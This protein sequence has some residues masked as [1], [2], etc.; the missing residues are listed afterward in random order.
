MKKKGL[1]ISTVVMVVVLIASLTTATYAWFTASNKTE[2]KGF[3]VS[4][5]SGNAVNIGMKKTYGFA[6]SATPDLFATGDV[7]FTVPTGGSTGAGNVNNPGEWGGTSDGFSATLNHNINWG[8]QKQAVGVTAEAD[9]TAD[10]VQTKT[11]ITN[12]TYWVNHNTDK[13]VVTYLNNNANKRT[14]VAANKAQGED[15]LVEQKLARANIGENDGDAG[16]YAHFILG[17]QPTKALSRNNFVI[18]VSPST[19]TS[20]LGVLASIHV[21]YRTKLDGQTASDWT[22]VDLYQNNH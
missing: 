3:D 5:V 18:T 16:D 19:S 9:V 14:V 22:E 1:I 13:G 12:T 11:N 15:K 4:V 7:T 17:V 6:D 8:S 20:T 2:I 10:N 21:A